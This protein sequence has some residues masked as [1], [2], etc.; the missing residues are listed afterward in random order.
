MTAHGHFKDQQ[1]KISSNSKKVP[2]T[3]VVKVESTLYLL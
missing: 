1:A 3:L 2:S